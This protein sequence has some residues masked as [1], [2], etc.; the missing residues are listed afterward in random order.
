MKVL[1][2]MAGLLLLAA[3][4]SVSPQPIQYGHD[5]CVQCAM[6]IMDHRY[7]TEVVTSTGK[8]YKF[9]SVECLVEFLEE[10]KDGKEQFSLVLVTPF[11][12]PQTLVDARQSYYLRSKDLPSPMGMYLTAFKEESTAMSFR[13]EFGGRVYCWERLNENFDVI[14][15][16]G[17]DN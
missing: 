17:I 8:A 4:C 12:H 15:L 14:R 6:T 9:D 2:I 1:I 10:H 3:S 11:N 5:N 16:K 7:G 13:E